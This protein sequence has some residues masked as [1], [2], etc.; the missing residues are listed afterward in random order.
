MMRSAIIVSCLFCS[1][2]L[3]IRCVAQDASAATAAP[4]AAAA[5]ATPATKP[6]YWSTQWTFDGID[7]AKL[8][9]RLSRIGIRLGLPLEGKVSVRFEVGVPWTSLTDA[10]AYRFDGTLTSPSLRVDN[11]QFDNLAARVTYRDGQVALNRLRAN[12]ITAQVGTPGVIEG[13]ATAALVPRG[14]LTASLNL[15][16]IALRPIMD[17]VMK[18]GASSTNTL[19][20]GGKVSGNVQF[21]VPLDSIS[22]IETYRLSGDVA[23]DA[24]ALRGLPPASLNINDIS[25]RTRILNLGRLDLT[26]GESAAE[27]IRLEGNATL[28]LDGS[29][30]FHFN[31]KGDDIPTQSVAALLQ[32]AS[33]DT[34]PSDGFTWVQGKLDFQSTGSGRFSKSLQESQW[35]IHAA[36]A[37]PG[38][39]VAGVELG[40]L[41]HDI[42]LTPSSLRIRPRRSVATLPNTVKIRVLSCDYRIQPNAVQIDSLDAQMFGGRLQGS[43]TIPSDGADMLLADV[44]FSQLRPT[45]RI[46]VAMTTAPDFNASISGE[47]K[48]QVPMASLA[49]PAAHLGTA[50]LKVADMRL[51]DEEL[52]QFHLALSAQAGEI[53]LRGEGEILDGTMRVNMVAE[54]TAE[55]RW[56][57]VLRRLR[58]YEIQLS[59]L[60]IR[61]VMF[62]AGTDRSDISGKISG[63]INGTTTPSLGS[64]G[65]QT[66]LDLGVTDLRYRDMLVSRQTSASSVFDGR[67]LTIDSLVGDYAG[68]TA[69]A[70]GRVELDR[71]NGAF[72]LR[73]DMTARVDRID[74]R[75]GLFFVPMVSEQVDGKGSGTIRLS[76]TNYAIRVRGNV[77][78]RQLVLANVALGTA[79]S[80]ILVDADAMTQRWKLRLPTIVAS[81]GGGSLEGELSVSSSHRG[82][83]GVD[84]S[85]RWKTRRVD[86]FH[87]SD[88][89]GQATSL[90]TGEITGEMTLGGKSVRGIDDLAGRFRFRLGETRG[91]AVPGLVGVGQWLGP[92]SLA[93]EKFDVGEAHGVIGNGVLTMDEFWLGSDAALIRADGQIFLRSQRM[94]IEA[95]IATGDYRDLAFD[96]Q[97]LA[98]RY[99]LRTLLP[100]SVILD[101]S[102]LLRDR[103]LVVR[104]LGRIDHP[105]VRLQTAETF[106]EEA[107]RFLIRESG[108]LIFTGAGVGVVGGISDGF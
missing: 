93:T 11:L 34:S 16:D 4:V 92:V 37:S 103:T 65:A 91:G 61:S 49:Q 102:E 90:A 82:T 81:V 70:N 29:G 79:H 55:D 40:V 46:P 75:R 50:E 97:R 6:R 84:L 14:D 96:L 28:P 13:S 104:I 32:S 98:Q 56:S 67:I 69:R 2:L 47:V 76:G 3:A 7:V 48:W 30:P 57:D 88:Q 58:K 35:D 17:L 27:S 105:I 18:V 39:R 85:S 45:I 63:A 5:P 66:Q 89:L 8:A 19:V 52:G 12:L 78:G 38:L 73:T 26:A 9:A 77:V 31:V 20:Q 99:L 44:H 53:D 83:R 80:G 87:L 107:A 42:Q 74:L 68:G 108:R 10:A 71:Q 33:G 1:P 41:E 100:S 54:A 51:G 95:L 72:Q 59:D 36:V 25:I 86:F 43:V 23:G 60:S 101:V 64:D 21:A 62:F 94:D 24:L 106:R 22:Q 15:E